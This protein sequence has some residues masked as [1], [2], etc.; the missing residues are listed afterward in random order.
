MFESDFKL[1]VVFWRHLLVLGC[2]LC[3]LLVFLFMQ[4]SDIFIFDLILLQIILAI[5]LL[6]LVISRAVLMYGA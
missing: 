4:I 5:V 3:A 1:I 2:N 6:I